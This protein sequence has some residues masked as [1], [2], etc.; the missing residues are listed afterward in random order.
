[1]NR[2]RISYPVEGEAHGIVSIISLYYGEAVLAFRYTANTKNVWQDLMF[3]AQ[4]HTCPSR[5]I[6]R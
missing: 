3:A 2:P 5:K 1:M 4:V 6:Q